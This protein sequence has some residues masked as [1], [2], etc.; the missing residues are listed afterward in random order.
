MKPTDEIIEVN[1]ETSKVLWH[2]WL[3][4]EDSC[5]FGK[6]RF[7]QYRD[8]TWHMSEQESRFLFAEVAAAKNYCYSVETPTQEV[9]SFSGQGK[10]SAST[11][12]TLYLSNKNYYNVEFKAKTPNIKGF[13]KDIEKLLREPCHGGNWFHSLKT[14]DNRTLRVLSSRFTESFNQQPTEKSMFVEKEIVFWICVIEK[15]EV[16]F[17]IWKYKSAVTDQDYS[18]DF[19]RDINTWQKWPEK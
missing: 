11:D 16:F 17:N 14:T 13:Q 8:E 3:T 5:Q 1:K 18:K 9:Y 7:S 15:Q 10:R 2:A 12:L 19:F 6:L 4:R